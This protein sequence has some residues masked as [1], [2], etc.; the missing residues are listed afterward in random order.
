M[1]PRDWRL[2]VED[3]L[4]SISAIAEFVRGMDLDAF[5]T[6]RKT[7]DAVIRNFIVIGEAANNVPPEV[8]DA[9]PEIPWKIMRDFRNFIVHVYFSVKMPVLWDTI[10]NDLPPLVPVLK[11]LLEAEGQSDK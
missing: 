4:D 2:R 6:D 5:Q 9:H 11:R 7:R 8:A 3:I 1:P 10:Q